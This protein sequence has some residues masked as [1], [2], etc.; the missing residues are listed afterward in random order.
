MFQLSLC[1]SGI[2]EKY[3]DKK[4]IELKQKIKEQG[5]VFSVFEK[6]EFIYFLIVANA[7]ANQVIQ[8]AKSFICEAIFDYFKQS[9]IIENLRYEETKDIRYHTLLSALLNFDRNCDEIYIKN[10]I[11]F[12]SNE[13]YIQS[14]YYF[15]CKILK[16]KWLQLL[17]ITNNNSKILHN[18]ENYLDVVRFL[19]EG[20]DKSNNITIETENN[21]FKVSSENESIN[22]TSYKSLMDYIIE[23]N[24][25]KLTLKNIDKNFANFVKQIFLT[26]VTITA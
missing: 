20:I 25:K 26:R 2:D 6:G 8:I 1:V 18:E 12:E 13:F 11:S 16:E 3:I 4:Q 23:N 10:K 7:N 15:C 14:F 9:F 21:Q 22:L 19:L 17:Q 24:P 5:G